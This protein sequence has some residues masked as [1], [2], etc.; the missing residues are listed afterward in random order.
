MVEPRVMVFTP[1]FG[2]EGAVVTHL[3]KH[4]PDLETKRETEEAEA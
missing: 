3:K 1:D 4:F 2:T